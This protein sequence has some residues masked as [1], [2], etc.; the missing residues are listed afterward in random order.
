[1]RDPSCSSSPLPGKQDKWGRSSESCSYEVCCARRPFP[2]KMNAAAWWNGF[3]ARLCLAGRPLWRCLS[4]KLNREPVREKC[5]QVSSYGRCRNLHGSISVGNRLPSGYHQVLIAGRQF[6]VHRLV[7]FAFLGPPPSELQWQV[8][9]CDGNPS[10]NCLKNLEYVTPSENVLHS[11]ADLSRRNA[12]EFSSQAVMWRPMGSQS[13]T[14][15]PSMAQA[16]AELGISRR[17]VSTACKQNKFVKG[18]EFQLARRN[19][20]PF[21]EGEEWRQMY[22]PVSGAEV[23]GRKVSSFGRITAQ[24][25][26]ISWGCQ[27]TNGYY[28]TRL[29]SLK[30]SESVHRLVAFAF[31]GAPVNSQFIHVNHKDLDKGNNAVENLEYVTPSENALHCKANMSSSPRSD[32]KAVE[33]RG[34]GSD[35]EW[36]LHPSIMSAAEELKVHRGS[37][38]KCLHGAIHQ[39]KGFEFRWPCAHAAAEWLD[40]EEWRKVDIQAHLLERADRKT[41]GRRSEEV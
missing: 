31:M 18:F 6:Y 29:S 35:G 27:Q 37:I 34:F 24:N 3:R 1:M 7:T 10:N 19:D 15:S 26:R 38:S 11:Y 32:R 28:C 9:H 22:D 2:F 41:L 16:A 23:L 33:S 20:S 8:N 12:G 4:T 21:L 13:W 17:S 30:R 14:T 36:R 40:G 5:W 39:A 25:G